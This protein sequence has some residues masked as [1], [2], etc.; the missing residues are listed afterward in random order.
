MAFCNCDFKNT[1]PGISIKFHSNFLPLP[2]LPHKITYIQTV[3]RQKLSQI[4][5]FRC[6]IFFPMPQ[7]TPDCDRVVVI[8]IPPSDG[9]DFNPLYVIKLIQLIMEIRTSEDYCR[10][11]IYV[12]DC[13][14]VSLC[15]ISKVTPSVVKKFELCALVSNI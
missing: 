1:F 7:L 8:D 15:H 12:A 10:S 13:G 5:L 9:M 14:N 3:L 4:W 2:P 6:R 11:D